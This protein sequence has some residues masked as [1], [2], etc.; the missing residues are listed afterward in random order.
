MLCVLILFNEWRETYSLKST[1][2]DKFF[3][4]L[5]VAI[6]IYFSEPL[7]EICWEEITEKNTFRILFRCLA[8]GLN[9]GFSSTKPTH[10]LL[11]HGDLDFNRQINC[12]FYYYEYPIEVSG[13]LKGGSSLCHREYKYTVVRTSKA[14]K[15]IITTCR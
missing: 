5:F 10:Y 7:P 11:D 13:K 9:P 2:N 1:P 14:L 3:K 4:K 6:F 12:F 8:W 15:A